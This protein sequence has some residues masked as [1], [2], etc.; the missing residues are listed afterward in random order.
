MFIQEQKIP[1][2]MFIQEQ[3]ITIGMFIQDFSKNTT[4]R[5]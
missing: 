1:I 4:S 5:Y 3:K 2:G